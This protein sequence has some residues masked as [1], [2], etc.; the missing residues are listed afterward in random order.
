MTVVREIQIF[1][2]LF[3]FYLALERVENIPSYAKLNYIFIN[4]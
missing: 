2:P 1:M 3:N 4:Q